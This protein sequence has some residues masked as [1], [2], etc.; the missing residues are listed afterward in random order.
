[1]ITRGALTIEL[2]DI[3]RSKIKAKDAKGCKVSN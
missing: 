1:M 2:D 3:S